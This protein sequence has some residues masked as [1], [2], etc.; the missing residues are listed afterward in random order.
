MKK[1]AVKPTAK[2]KIIPSPKTVPTPKIVER[3]LK[4]VSAEDLF[5]VTDTNMMLAIELKRQPDA[6]IYK[7]EIGEGQKFFPYG[8][9]TRLLIGWE[10]VGFISSFEMKLTP[11]HP[12]PQ[13]IVRFAEA[14]TP[15]Q[16]KEMDPAIRAQVEA[17]IAKVRQ[18]P[19]VTIESPL[20]APLKGA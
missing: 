19:F 2:S 13:I 4:K 20:L 9:L 16:V 11:A 8:V 10:T 18:F 3:K 17:Q 7:M 5:E 15:E 14:M 12:L 1:P 6:S